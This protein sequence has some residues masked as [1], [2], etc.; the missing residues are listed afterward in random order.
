MREGKAL[1]TLA[2]VPR[3]FHKKQQYKQQ[4]KQQFHSWN[5]TNC[6]I[7]SLEDFQCD[8]SLWFHHKLSLIIR[9][10]FAEYAAKAVEWE[11][12]ISSMYNFVTLFATGIG[13]SLF[14]FVERDFP[15]RELEKN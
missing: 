2:S 6:R 11:V 3:A 15:L 1:G 13:F 8:I 9:W 10:R 14:D 7:G 4:Y 5:S 12:P